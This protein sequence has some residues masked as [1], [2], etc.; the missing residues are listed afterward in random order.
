MA[1]GI[2]T[3]ATV[4]KA[5]LTEQRLRDRPRLQRRGNPA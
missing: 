2:K 1:A 4:A 5:R 3:G